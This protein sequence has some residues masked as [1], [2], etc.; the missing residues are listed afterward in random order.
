LQLFEI[1]Q[2]TPRKLGET[3]EWSNEVLDQPILVDDMVLEKVRMEIIA[4]ADDALLISLSNCK[5][6]RNGVP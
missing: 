6:S 1:R 5:R 2:T 4:Q 3:G